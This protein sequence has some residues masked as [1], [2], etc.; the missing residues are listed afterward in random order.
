VG[1]IVKVFGSIIAFA[2]AWLAPP[3]PGY[4]EIVQHGDA[5]AVPTVWQAAWGAHDCQTKGFEL[6]ENAFV[7][8]N[9]KGGVERRI[10]SL[11]GSGINLWL[12]FDE[13]PQVELRM[14]GADSMVVGLILRGGPAG[15]MY[16]RLQMAEVQNRCTSS[17]TG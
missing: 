12:T 8:Y 3:P 9:P 15:R 7:T 5:V 2:L 6:T 16:G 4:G 17:K 11:I 14:V 10:R 13:P 1:V